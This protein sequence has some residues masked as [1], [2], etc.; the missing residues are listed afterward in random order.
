MPWKLPWAEE[1]PVERRRRE[2]AEQSSRLAEQAAALE[3]E[4]H[5]ASEPQ[6]APAQ[7]QEF[8]RP[9]PPVW[10][11]EPELIA[12]P[13]PAKRVLAAK[14]RRDRNR[15]IVC[16][17]LLVGILAWMFHAISSASQ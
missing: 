14:R 1:D 17:I 13:R 6:T 9:E 16:F 10:K 8:S 12:Q 7:E 2:L 3:R 15:F 11:A 5:R 4:L